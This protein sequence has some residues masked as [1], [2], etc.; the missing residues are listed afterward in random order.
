MVYMHGVQGVASSN[1]AT[2]TRTP[3]AS[4]RSHPDL[5]DFL[6]WIKL[7]IVCGRLIAFQKIR[8]KTGAALSRGFE[9]LVVC[10]GNK[11]A[12]LQCGLTVPAVGN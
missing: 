1:P 6:L 4:I 10:A 12:G 2:P 5:A 9:D 7:L 11:T 3:S 8:Y